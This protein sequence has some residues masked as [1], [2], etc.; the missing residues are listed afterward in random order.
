MQSD[1]RRHRGPR[2]AADNE[3]DPS[4]MATRRAVCFIQRR[5]RLDNRRKPRGLAT[6]ERVEERRA[7]QTDRQRFFDGAVEHRL[8]GRVGEVRDEQRRLRAR[9]R[10]APRRRRACHAA[11]DQAPTASG[12][13]RRRVSASAAAQ[14]TRRGGGASRRSCASPARRPQRAR[15]ALVEARRARPRT[16]MPLKAHGRSRAAG[17]ARPGCRAPAA[18]GRSAIAPA[19]APASCAGSGPAGCRCRRSARSPASIS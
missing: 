12:R 6:V 8:A 17:S 9:R 10:S 11:P 19:A 3:I 15:A 2:L 13:E 4:R 5:T 16:P 14:P 1:S 18:P 7:L